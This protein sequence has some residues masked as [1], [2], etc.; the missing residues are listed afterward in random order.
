MVPL[1]IQIVQKDIIRPLT[2]NT[3]KIWHFFPSLCSGLVHPKI[4]ILSS[5]TH[6]HVVPNPK[7]FVHLQNT[8]G[9]DIIFTYWTKVLTTLQFKE[10]HFAIKLTMYRTFVECMTIYLSYCEEIKSTK[11]NV[12]SELY[13]IETGW[14]MSLLPSQSLFPCFNMFHDHFSF[15]RC[16]RVTLHLV[17]SY[18]CVTSTDTGGLIG[19][20]SVRLR[21]ALTQGRGLIKTDTQTHSARTHTNTL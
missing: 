4:L 13:L 15:L 3:H 17:V 12:S 16:K 9:G 2:K 1:K 18:E 6:P 11:F 10:M 8:N 14:I 21:N 20:S 7:A 19:L 5:V